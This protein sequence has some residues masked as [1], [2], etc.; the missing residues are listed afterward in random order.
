MSAFNALNFTSHD[1]QLEAEEHSRELQVEE[2]FKIFQGALYDLKAK[3]FAEADAKFED[4]FSMEVLKPNKWGFYK[5]SSPTLDSLRY[6]AYRNRGMYYCSYLIENYSRLDPQDIVDYVLKVVENLLES[7]QHSEADISVTRLLTQIFRSYKSKRLERLILEYELTKRENHLV[8]LGRKRKGLLPSLMEIVVQYENL[9]KSIKADELTSRLITEGL[10]PERV[11]ETVSSASLG[12]ILS[13]IKKMKTIDEHTMR[14]LDASQVALQECNW[15]AIATSL[16]Q[17]VPHVK[18]SILVTKSTDPYHEVEF[19]I[20][21]VQ[22]IITEPDKSPLLSTQISEEGEASE[23]PESTRDLSPSASTLA[24]PGESGDKTEEATSSAK[25][26]IDDSE[27]QKFVQRSSKRFK[28]KDQEATEE[29]A[30]RVHVIFLSDLSAMLGI[31][32]LS[33]PPNI[34]NLSISMIDPDNRDQLPQ[35]DLIGCLKSWNSWHTEIY[36]R[37]D[38][39]SASKSSK[40]SVDSDFLQVNTLLRSN[41]FGDKIDAMGA[42]PALDDEGAKSFLDDIN[43]SPMHFQEVRFR[44]LVRLLSKDDNSGIRPIVD[45]LW[46]PRLYDAMEWFLF[47]VERN[48]YDFISENMKNHSYLALSVHEMLVNMLGK[49]CEEITAKKLQGNK[50]TDL[51]HQRNQLESEIEKWHALL[52]LHKTEDKEW[53]LYFEWSHYCFLQYCCEIID[54]RLLAVLTSIEKSLTDRKEDFHA[55]FPNYHHVPPLHIK[56]IHSQSRRIR[57]IRRISIIDTSEND[58]K[59]EDEQQNISLLR[60][61]LLLDIYPENEPP[62]EILEM[63]RFVS[64]SPFLLKVKLWEVLFNSSLNRED[65]QIVFQN[66]FHVLTFFSKF[67]T[68][69]RYYGQPI[70]VRQQLLLITLSSLE[71]F[72]S[73]FSD[74]ILRNGHQYTESIDRS[75][76]DLL[77]RAFFL[78]YPVLYFE[79]LSKSDASLKSFF[80]KATKSSTKM[81]NAIA[82]LATL[83]IY[84]YDKEAATRALPQRNMLT[85]DLIECFHGLLGEFKSC[86]ASEG[87]LLKLSESLLCQSTDNGSLAPLK[88]ILWCRYHYLIAGDNF[89]P[90]QHI[91]K[92]VPMDKSNSLSLGVYL[93][94]LQSQGRNPMLASGSKA[95]LKPVFDSIIETVGDPTSSGNHVVERNKFLLE[96]YLESPITARIFQEAFTG[97]NCL[98]LTTPNDELQESMDAGLFYVASV[99]ALNL[100]GT[101]KKSMQARPSELDSIITMLKT[102]IIYNTGRFESW[103]LLGRCYSFIVEDDLMWTSDKLSTIEKKSTIALKQRTAI[104]CYIMSLKLFYAKKI[105]HVDDYRIIKRVME[106]LGTELIS[107]SHKPMEK[108]CFSWRRSQSAL[109]LTDEGELTERKEEDSML[110]SSFNINQAILFCFHR[111]NLIDDKSSEDSQRNWMN[112]YHI[113]R[114]L[115]KNDRSNFWKQASENILESCR[116]AVE[117]SAPKDPI[118]EPHY[119]LVDVCYKTVK[120]ALASPITMLEILAKDDSFFKQEDTFWKL[121]NSLTL[122]YQ[123]KVFYDKVIKLLT[124]ILASDKKKWHHRPKYRIAKILLDEFNNVEGAANEIGTLMSIKST[125]K[126]LVNIWKPDHERPGKHF[127]YAYQYVMFYLDLLRRIGDFNSIGLVCKK[128]RRFSSGMAYVNKA[129]EHATSLY[130]QCARDRLQLDEKMYMEKILPALNY[131][132][133]L[134]ASEQLCETFQVSDYSQETLQALKISYQLKRGNNGIAFDGICLAIFLKFFYLPKC[135]EF[136]ID[137]KSS[138]EQIQAKELQQEPRQLIISSTTTSRPSSQASSSQKST[139]PRKRVSKKDAFDKI[140]LWVEKI[141]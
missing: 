138:P 1:E 72:S 51:N 135:D 98:I 128:I 8:L 134:R 31:L 116:L 75:K 79:S 121:D 63:L 36:M 42:F 11:V 49:V 66:Y 57:I 110:I 140:R 89:Q 86:D 109:L 115:F 68:S 113:G 58:M 3:R 80:R 88:Q 124:F 25:R 101:R 120:E 12:Q 129:A 24:A 73:K 90:K 136:S 30:L 117:S 85:A 35:N 92:E 74:F 16:K 56:A 91:T 19:P 52:Q 46:S 53:S 64:G 45:R 118:I 131:Q 20:E 105:K 23:G 81:K 70:K 40:K 34:E 62:A 21:A 65:T 77:M 43:K 84:F 100:Y 102:D 5:Y 27:S 127:V 78:F 38:I 41:V 4:L 44:L 96:S 54:D 6:L 55:V 71:D 103:Y 141:T 26:P 107:G 17:L 32:G 59:D 33:P 94:K 47:G 69:D 29:D 50:S 108:L 125:H 76:F 123:R 106:A 48:L 126:N 112:F 104:L 95:A 82:N 130:I 137:D 14:E 111:A 87:K 133:F 28:E 22:F 139:I 9:L 37:H 60:Q 15:E 93:I 99:Q 10:V 2:S 13:R 39:G 119:Y 61:V 132:H 114:I 83:L 18:T 67:L 122:D 97:E 7:I